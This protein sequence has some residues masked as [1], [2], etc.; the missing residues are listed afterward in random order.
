MLSETTL[1]LWH[2][3]IQ[4]VFGD[5]LSRIRAKILPAMLRRLIPRWLSQDDQS[6]LFLYRWIML[7]S[8]RCWGRWSCSQNS[9]NS[10]VRCSRRWC[11]PALI[12]SMGIPSGLGAL[13]AWICPTALV[14]SSMLGGVSSSK[15]IGLRCTDSI[16]SSVTCE[17]WFNRL[18]KCSV[19]CLRMSYLSVRRTPSELRT[20][21]VGFL[22]GPKRD[23]RPDY[24]TLILFLS[25][26]PCISK[27]FGP[28]W[29]LHLTRTS[30]HLCSQL[31]K[32]GVF[33][34]WILVTQ[35]C[36]MCRMLLL[37]ELKY[38]LV[39]LIEPVLV[40]PLSEP[41]CRFSWREYCISGGS[42]C[43]FNCGS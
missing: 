26:F 6:P 31:F 22:R 5:T 43:I 32:L 27:L 9:W 17:G 10:F 25:S 30:P 8:R 3:V 29:I 7:V 42:S 20:R 18:E 1:A 16:V 40:F 41:K 15:M 13:P 11:P 38:F 2:H 34:S 21:A 37:Y 36:S 23:F 4:Q 33:W 28:P 19:H 14:V 35:P 24:S 39:T 12:I